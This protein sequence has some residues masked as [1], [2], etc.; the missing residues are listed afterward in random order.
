MLEAPELYSSLSSN[1]YVHNNKFNIPSYIDRIL[2]RV[3]II[4]RFENN[5]S[6]IL[7]QYLPVNKHGFLRKSLQKFS[8]DYCFE[9]KPM[10]KK[11]YLDLCCDYCNKKNDWIE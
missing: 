10:F 5:Q 3:G 1:E 11:C 2:K 8:E 6:E 7:T 9:K 4:S